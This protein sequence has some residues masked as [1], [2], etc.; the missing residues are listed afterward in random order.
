M[1]E[2]IGSAEVTRWPL[3]YKGTEQLLEM[4]QHVRKLGKVADGHTSGCSY[5]KLNSLAAAGISACHE[6][7]TA[8]EALDR[9][10]LGLW[11][12]LRNSSLRPD[13]PELMKLVTEG[14][15]PTHRLLMTTDGP[16]PGFI[17]E[18][19]CVGGLVKSAVQLGVSPMQALQ[20][21]TINPATY[22][23]LEDQ[24]GGIAPGRLADLLVL[25][26]LK[27]F[28]P[29]LVISGGEL[30]AEDGRLLL[31][32]PA[33]DW[34]S[35]GQEMPFTLDPDLLAD[36]QIYPY[37]PQTDE[38]ALPVIHFRSAVI[39]KLVER[40]A[41]IGNNRVP[42]QDGLL[43]AALIDRQG[44]WI[45]RGILER[46]AVAIDGFASTYNT[47]THLLAIGRDP[48]AMAQAASRVRELG[49][50]IVLVERGEIILEIRLPLAGMM[51]TDPDFSTA[52]RCHQDLIT[53]MQERGYPFH[54]ILYSLLFLTC[55]SLPG[56]RLT[57]YGLYEV[58]SDRIVRA[59]ETLERKK[60]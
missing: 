59:A 29:S 6:A 57:P 55:D 14:K 40:D 20:M 26:D 58:K 21:A 60:V 13:F 10:R 44:K 35:Y 28:R 27:D 23:K 30:A 32:V 5:E 3:L 38:R 48:R 34:D 19:G 31:P 49:G 17:E 18:H 15:I 43:W 45:S 39:T 36:P 41:G 24:V 42:G 8:K 46:F 56:L 52:V 2:V 37:R 7:I 50:G 25:P 1:D 47:T 11:T 54:D 16:H 12:V 33:I 51:L 9:L 53:A 22:L 4:T